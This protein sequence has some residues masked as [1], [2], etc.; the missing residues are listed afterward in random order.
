MRMCGCEL[1][2]FLAWFQKGVNNGAS[3]SQMSV[4]TVSGEGSKRNSATLKPPLSAAGR[5]NSIPLLHSGTKFRHGLLQL[6]IQSIDP[7]HD[8]RVDEKA[9]Q[10]GLIRLL[11]WVNININRIKKYCLLGHL[12][13]CN[14]VPQGFVGCGQDRRNFHCGSQ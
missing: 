8:G 12:V 3:S 13:T 1:A 11:N 14:S 10:V 2:F 6:M 5:R 4:Q 9:T 7:L